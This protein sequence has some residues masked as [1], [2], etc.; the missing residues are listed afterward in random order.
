M[1]LEVQ[2][3][4]SGPALHRWSHAAGRSVVRRKGSIYSVRCIPA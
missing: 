3:K 4:G 1:A 2:S